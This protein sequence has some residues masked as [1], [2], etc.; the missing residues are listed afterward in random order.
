[1]T[2]AAFQD[3][4]EDPGPPAARGTR[5]FVEAVERCAARPF[6]SY[7]AVFL[8]QLKVVWGA[9]L[10]RDLTSGDTASYFTYAERWLRE[11][12]LD[13]IWS[14]LYT[15][16]YGALL[17]LTPGDA[18]LP[19]IVHRLLI[20]VTSTLLLLAVMRRL[21]TP[22]LALL[23]ALWWA[24]LPGTFETA[25]EVHLFATIPVF[26]CWLV[27]LGGQGPGHRGAALAILAAGAVLVRNELGLAVLVLAVFCLVSEVR[28]RRAPGQ[29]NPP[30]AGRYLIAYGLPM[31][32]A[33]VACVAVYSRAVSPLPEML[34]RSP[35]K[36]TTNMC[37]V[38][39]YG[40]KQRHPEVTL[41]HWTE[42]GLLMREHFGKALPSL[43]EMIRR[44]PRAVATHFAWNASLTGNGLQMVLFN[45]MSGTVTPDYGPVPSR[46][47]RAAVLSILGIAALIAGAV[48]ILRGPPPRLERWLADRAWGWLAI[49]AMVPVWIA[50]ILTQRPRP[51]Y[52]L[53]LGAAVMA[54]LGTSLLVTAWVPLTRRMGRS[55]LWALVALVAA[56]LLWWPSYYLPATR[57]ILALYRRHLPFEALIA[58]RNTVLLTSTRGFE[59]QFYVGRGR[60]RVLEYGQALAHGGGLD[61]FLDEEGVNMFYADES[62]LDALRR[63]GRFDA[64]LDSVQA[65]EW[66]LVGA[67]D[68]ED[69]RWRMWR[70]P[71]AANVVPRPTIDPELAGWK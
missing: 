15:A 49:L 19:T 26:A 71:P 24:V 7:L 29:A 42:C 65:G 34:A 59:L 5:R 58:R 23:V 14:P 28:A 60:P 63:S 53:A 13:L 31:L 8:V 68:L 18:Y 40:Y 56:L 36:H 43:G 16:L 48:G 45:A 10:Y 33:A 64:L 39:A 27:I 22:G 1:M 54:A 6:A 2:G 20:V 50:I 52:L 30:R 17:D 66:T 62:M 38:Y 44:N 21:L 46:S 57:P 12:R 55:G 67:Q 4:T 3:S 70:R 61:R 25:V 47:T 11:G 51:S 35:R 69:A 32:L 37:Q 9:W 41:D